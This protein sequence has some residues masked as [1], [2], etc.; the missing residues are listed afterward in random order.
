MDENSFRK[1]LKLIPHVQRYLWGRPADQSIIGKLVKEYDNLLTAELW[2]G[3]H[4]E[5]P[6]EIIIDGENLPLDE[7]IEKSHK[8]KS[9]TKEDDCSSPNPCVK[10][11]NISL[12]P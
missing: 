11:E 2:L 5:L 7:A 8:N 12:H 3:A 4:P 9:L 1:P 10:D 6:S